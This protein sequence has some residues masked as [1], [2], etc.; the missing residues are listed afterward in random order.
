MLECCQNVTTISF[1]TVFCFACFILP[2]V[3]KFV[4]TYKLNKY[5]PIIESIENYKQQN[6]TYPQTIEDSIKIFERFNYEIHNNGKDYKLSVGNGWYTHYSYCSSENIK[7]CKE[8]RDGF[9]EYKKFGKW[10]KAV[11]DD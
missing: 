9:M 2:F 5:N 8:G 1:V 10:I 6:G 3:D 4:F 7:G 11:Y